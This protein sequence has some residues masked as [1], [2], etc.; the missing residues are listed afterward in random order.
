MEGLVPHARRHAPMRSAADQGTLW[1]EFLS[2]RQEYEEALFFI[3][4]RTF[5]EIDDPA[6]AR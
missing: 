2:F 1:Q 6:S 5:A 3:A 4:R